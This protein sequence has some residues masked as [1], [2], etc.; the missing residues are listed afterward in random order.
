MS[1]FFSIF[2][3]FAILLGGGFYLY[4]Q[5]AT[6][7]AEAR[8]E[9]QL[10][11][12][13]RTFADKARSA[14]TEEESEDYLRSIQAALK[15]YDDELNKVYKEH[16]DW[17]DPAGY[18]KRVETE[19]KEG[20]L[21]EAQRKSMLEGYRIVK[22]SYDTLMGGKWEPILTQLGKGDTRMD[23]YEVRRIRDD[24]GNPILEGKFFFWGLE[25][26]TRVN[27]GNIAL[28]FWVKREAT[29]GKK[30]RRRR[31][32]EPELVE[33]VLGKAD[34]EATPRLILQNPSN[35]IDEFPS[36]LSVGY[37]WLPVMPREA[38][39]VDIEYS[40]I[41]KKGGTAPESYLKWERFQIPSR[42]QLK[43]GEEWEADVVE[44]SEDEIAGTE[45]DAGVAEEEE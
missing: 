40:Y 35:Y 39:A 16:P 10:V 24:A 7:D 8:I 22:E 45:P 33:E 42:W 28:K 1:R 18:E 29:V 13:R 41:A 36:F 14:I 25:E 32:E 2:I 20:K 30:K 23:L 34:G 31:G 37:I 12:A 26:N 3:I 9:E 21:N 11:D 4:D 15:T 43:D 27:W 6:Q 17:R 44:A 5:K 19:F 38:H